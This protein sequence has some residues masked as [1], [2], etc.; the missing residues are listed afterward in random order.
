[1]TA[2]TLPGQTRRTASTVRSAGA[3]VWRVHKGQLEVQ[4]VHRPRYK[5]WSWPKGKL[6]P[7][8]AAPAAAVREVAEETGSP[9]VLGQ[10]LPGLRY[11]LSDGKL[12]YVHYWAARRS[13]E[14][15]AAAVTARELTPPVD[16]HEIDDATWMVPTKAAKTLTRA[17]DRRP[18]KALVRAWEKGNLDTQPF[19]LARH[20]RARKRSAWKGGEEDRPLTPAGYVQAAALVP[21]LSAFGI[22]RIVT[23]D[24]LRCSDTIAPYARATGLVAGASHD[25]TETVHEQSPAVVR[26]IVASLLQSPTPTV[27]CTHRP[28]L[29]TALAVIAAHARPSVAKS[30]PDENPYLKPAQMLVA[31]VVHGP[32]GPR[33]VAAEVARPPYPV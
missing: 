16:I 24:W 28:V 15:D 14:A 18:L 27:L 3:L 32:E 17:A 23:S 12:K 26:E 4:L 22:G 31:H 8:E 11:R 13:G 25:L 2:V 20:A 7:L 10:P 19:V 21:L 9:I 30:L 29:P 33:V 5:D 6:D 1:M